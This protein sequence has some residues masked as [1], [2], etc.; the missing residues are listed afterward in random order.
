MPEYS[1]IIEF[2]NKKDIYPRFAYF[3]RLPGGP[4]R[5]RIRVDLPGAMRRFLRIHEITHTKDH[6]AGGY[7]GD[8]WAE[9]EWEANWAAA[10]QHPWGACLTILWSLAPYR[11]AYYWYRFRTGGPSGESH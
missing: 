4:Y 1:N 5:I 7:T 3:E 9:N 6:F 2:C 10:R 8:H 11:L